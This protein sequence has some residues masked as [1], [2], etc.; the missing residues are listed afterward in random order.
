MPRAHSFKYIVKSKLIVTVF[1]SNNGM[2][3]EAPEKTNLN[4]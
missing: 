2:L 3:Q 1:Q 4:S